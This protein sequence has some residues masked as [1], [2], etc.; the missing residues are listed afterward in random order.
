M[1]DVTF[2]ASDHPIPHHHYNILSKIRLAVDLK[3][4]TIGG[5]RE[6]HH[7]ISSTW[8]YCIRMVNRR[9]TRF[10]LEGQCV[11]WMGPLILAR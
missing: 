3:V 6:R 5:W 4:P 7:N 11:S 10:A 2:R 9:N 1:M 8:M